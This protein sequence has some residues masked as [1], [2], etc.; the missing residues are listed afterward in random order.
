MRRDDPRM[1]GFRHRWEVADVERL[2]IER[3]GSLEAQEVPVTQAAGRVLVA[4]LLASI[5][6]PGFDRSAMDGYALRGEDTFGASEYA[7]IAFRV[8]GESMP[9]RAFAGRVGPGEAVRIMTGA[10]LPRGADAVLMAEEARGG[11]ERMEA[12]GAVPP[13]RHVSRA[14]E[15]VRR[16]ETILRAGRALRPQDVGLLAALGVARLGVVRRPRVDVVVTGNELLPAGRAPRGHRIVDA[17]SPMLAALVRR[18]GGEPHLARIVRDDPELLESALAGCRGD[19]VLLTGGSSVGVEDHAPRV[20]ERLGELAVHGVA[21]RPSS[22]TGIGF[23]GGRPVFLLPGNPLSCLCAYDFFA[24]PTLR[25][26][27]GRDRGWPYATVEARLVA[28]VTSQSGR[29]DYLRV[30]L[31][32][33]RATPLMISGAGILSSAVRADGFVVLPRDS[34]GLAAGAKVTVYLYG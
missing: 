30:A 22:P 21:M 26:L 16:G 8:V 4:D 32:E 25:A 7:P 18:D 10:P 19:A 29:V 9:G 24:G 31:H 11:G 15:D 5:D 34:E 2:L 23:V 17:N 33:G 12:V 27:G 13:G 1:R 14:G 20:V 3:V 6:L 28:K